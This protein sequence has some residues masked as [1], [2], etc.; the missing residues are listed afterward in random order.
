[1][2]RIISLVRYK[3]M[4]YE[5]RTT[6]VLLNSECKN[7]SNTS[8]QLIAKIPKVDRSVSRGAKY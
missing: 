8:E 6:S 3:F 1:M 4:D 7:A 2:P 5:D